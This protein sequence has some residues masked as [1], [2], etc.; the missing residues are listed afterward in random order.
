MTVPGYVLSTEAADDLCDIRDYIAQ[1]NPAAARQV[2]V[3]LR[4]AMRRLAQ[5]PNL[6]HLRDDLADEPLRFW[7]VRSYLIVYRPD[8]R[9]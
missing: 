5:M 6:G 1:D 3:D 9:P 2:L 8:R 4:E 7:P